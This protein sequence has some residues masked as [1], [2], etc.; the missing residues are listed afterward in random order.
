MGG[1]VFR[2]KLLL[3]WRT[4]AS[5]IFRFN[6]NTYMRPVLLLSCNCQQE[7]NNNTVDYVLYANTDFPLEEQI[8]IPS[9]YKGTIPLDSHSSYPGLCGLVSALDSYL[10]CPLPYQR[11]RTPAEYEAACSAHF[12]PSL[13]TRS[14]DVCIAGPAAFT[15]STA[16][17]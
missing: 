15:C 16:M 17:G 11:N 1:F 8:P 13:S 12:N 14:L 6:W 4:S 10:T 3:I 2:L 5:S 7:E 9:F